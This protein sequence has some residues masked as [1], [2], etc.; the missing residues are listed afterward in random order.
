MT[1]DLL[2]NTRTLDPQ[3]EL[4]PPRQPV[5]RPLRR[6]WQQI[7][8][9]IRL[10]HLNQLRLSPHRVY[11][12]VPFPRPRVL[13][14]P[15]RVRPLELVRSLRGLGAV[16][17]RGLDCRGG[18]PREEALE[19]PRER[20]G[21]VDELLGGR[22]GRG[23]RNGVPAFSLGWFRPV[24][25]V[26]RG[27]CPLGG[28]ECSIVLLVAP[29]RDLI[30]SALASRFGVRAAKSSKT[31]GQMRGRAYVTGGAPLLLQL[32]KVASRSRSVA[33]RLEFVSR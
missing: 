7:L 28:L 31:M 12:V 20:L 22:H 19:L 33:T 13:P 6:L 5:L 21:E 1:L 9:A 11:R 4:H 29:S 16:R 27:P 3:P 32:C 8:N 24:V 15:E 25:R 30:S 26:E 17:R 18:V 2:P 10:G 14:E 23:R